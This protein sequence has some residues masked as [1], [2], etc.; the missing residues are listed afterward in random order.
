MQAE[1]PDTLLP[2]PRRTADSQELLRAE[3][4]QVKLSECACDA[5]LLVSSMRA[6]A[7]W[8]IGPLV[9]EPPLPIE[10]GSTRF[11]VPEV[12]VPPLRLP[13]TPLMSE[14]PSQPDASLTR[15]MSPVREVSTVRK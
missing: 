14:E 7:V 15:F 3:P 4:V 9:V 6:V 1:Q 11:K 10:P 2:S 13:A 12:R 8:L 5:P